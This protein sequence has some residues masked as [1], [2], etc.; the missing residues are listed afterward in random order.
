MKSTTFNGKDCQGNAYAT[1]VYK[2]DK[3]H[4]FDGLGNYIMVESAIALKTAILGMTLA[5]FAY[6]F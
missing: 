4:D 6:Q 5:L 1:Y 3:C 2:W